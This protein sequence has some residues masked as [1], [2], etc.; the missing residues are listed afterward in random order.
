MLT[1][2]VYSP[3]R[4]VAT[5]CSISSTFLSLLGIP[6]IRQVADSEH[7][8]IL[9][10]RQTNLQQRYWVFLDSFLCEYANP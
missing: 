9:R 3:K 4:Q 1:G 2:F 7:V 10:N 5:G 8:D 6:Q